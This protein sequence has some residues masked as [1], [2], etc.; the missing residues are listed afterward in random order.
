MVERCIH[1]AEV[2]GSS[3]ASSTAK[4]S[5]YL[6][7]F[8]LAIPVV[9]LILFFS[10]SQTLTFKF[11]VPTPVHVTSP[12]ILVPSVSVNPFS[13]DTEVL[14]A[15]VPFTSQAPFGNW[16][17]DR[18]QDGCE[19]ATSL[20]AVSWA[21][22][23]TFTPAQAL[24]SIHDASKY[25]Q[26]TYGEYRDV[27]AADTVVRIIQGFFGY[28]FAR[29]QPDITISDIVNELSRGNLVI[30]PVNG[31]LLGN[32]YFTPPGPE[33]HMVVIRGYDPEK[34]EFITNDP[35]TKRGL[36]YRYPQDTLYT[37]LRDY[38]TGYHILIPEVKKNMIVVSPLP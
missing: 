32:P 8:L 25:Q 12:T 37:A 23:Q 5:K 26:D 10:T 4:V 18:Q 21:R 14:L 11:A 3:P 17:D 13:E 35:G 30:T 24:Q 6:L 36:L 7:L 20:M 33:R 29:F 31:Q 22:R 2:A 28:S 16:D 19:E 34:Q 9:L 38:H 15:N 27:S 1:I